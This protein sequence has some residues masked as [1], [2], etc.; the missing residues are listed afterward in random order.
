MNFIY[1]QRENT[2][3]RL[4]NKLTGCEEKHFVPG[5]TGW[6]E[7]SINW[8]NSS[9]NINSYN[10]YTWGCNGFDRVVEAEERAVAGAT[11]KAQ[12]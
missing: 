12:L 9:Y 6:M 10:I 4:G 3:C 1:T 11:L 5:V 8:I 7:L 2:D